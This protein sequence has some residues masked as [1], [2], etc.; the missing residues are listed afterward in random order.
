MENTSLGQFEDMGKPG[1]DEVIEK[2]LD[3]SFWLD[4][5]KFEMNDCKDIFDIISHKVSMENYCGSKGKY[6]E[7]E[8]KVASPKLVEA[9]YHLT[10]WRTTDGDSFGPLVRGMIATKDGQKVLITYG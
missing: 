1:Y 2:E 5:H 4:G 10:Y 7:W 6:I 9:G 3:S 8:N